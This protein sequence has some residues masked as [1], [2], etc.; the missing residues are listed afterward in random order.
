MTPKDFMA[1]ALAVLGA[2]FLS[3]G[4]ASVF[5]KVGPVLYLALGLLWMLVGA[6]IYRQK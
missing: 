2:Y 4:I 5:A 6:Q 3:V 1:V